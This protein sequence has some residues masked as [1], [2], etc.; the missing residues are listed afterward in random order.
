MSEVMECEF[1]DPMKLVLMCNGTLYDELT[2]VE[3]GSPMFWV[4]LLGSILSIL[5]AGLMSGLGMGLLSLDVTTMMAMAGASSDPSERQNIQKLLPIL[6]RQHLLLVT[7][8]LSNAMAMETLPLL[9]DRIVSAFAAVIISV[10]AVLFFGEIIPQA[11][12]KK[13]GIAIGAN[14]IYIT[15][16]LM[17]VTFPITWPISKLLDL[18]LGHTSGTYFRR[19]QLKELVKLHGVKGVDNKDPLTH[20]EIITIRGVLGMKDMTV[21]QVMVPRLKIFSLDAGRSLDAEAVSLI[22]SRGF[23]RIPITDANNSEK[24][25]GA[26]VVKSLLSAD[27]ES[28]VLISSVPLVKVLEVP[29]T[30]SL[31]EL[32]NEFIVKDVHICVVVDQDYISGMLTMEDLME[33]IIQGKV[34]RETSATGSKLTQI[35]RSSKHTLFFFK[36][37]KSKKRIALSSSDSEGQ[38]SLLRTSSSYE[39]SLGDVSDEG[40]DVLVDGDE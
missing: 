5:F 1:V 27:L 4:Y 22:V 20:N 12:C 29:P 9:L 38:D 16:A 18:I 21:K 34:G 8:L 14:T 10:T 6:K 33:Q 7:L 13:Y 2:Q 37:R 25:V 35:R 15:L 24:V 28:N 23:S 36:P 3:A 30:M 17:I 32:W 31:F 19:D 39:V 26:L 40:V 11:I